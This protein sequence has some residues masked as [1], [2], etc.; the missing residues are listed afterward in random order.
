M[1]Q[2]FQKLLSGHQI[3][4][5]DGRPDG[6]PHARTH[7]RTGVT[8][9]D[10]PPFFEWRGHKNT[11]LLQYQTWCNFIERTPRWLS[12]ILDKLIILL[13]LQTLIISGK[14]NN[15]QKYAVG[16][17][18][19]LNQP[20]DYGSIMHYGE[21]AMSIDHSKY[22]IEPKQPGVTIG[23]RKEM[24]PTDIKSTVAKFF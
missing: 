20:Y 1:N 5:T 19:M 2:I 4:I 11:I 8:L 6:R 17:V 23:H 13:T 15:F 18:D 16:F 7:A 10:P 21:H 3:L 14:E 24:S 22:T 9:N 12:A